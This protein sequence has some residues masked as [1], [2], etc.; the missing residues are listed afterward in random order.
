MFI[1]FAII[2]EQS[3]T[4]FTCT[5]RLAKT[6]FRKCKIVTRD[7]LDQSMNRKKMLPECDYL[8]CRQYHAQKAR[9]RVAERENKSIRLEREDRFVNGGASTATNFSFVCV[10]GSVV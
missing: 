9:R 1:F 5:V 10:Y 2:W 6:R 8:A 7:W 3:L 4:E